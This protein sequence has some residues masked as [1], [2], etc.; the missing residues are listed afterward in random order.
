MANKY[1]VTGGTTTSWN[2]SSNWSLTSGGARGAAIPV[3]ADKVFFDQNAT[4]TVTSTGAANFPCCSL[5]VSAGLVTFALTGLFDCGSTSVAGDKEFFLGAGNVVSFTAIGFAFYTQTATT[6]TITTNGVPLTGL[7][8]P[9]GVAF[10]GSSA[11]ATGTILL[12]DNLSIAPTGGYGFTLTYGTLNLNNNTI[13][14]PSYNGSPTAATT[15]TIAFSTS[16]KLSIFGFGAT[17]TAT[18]T[19]SPFNVG[20]G[21]AHAVTGTPTV[22]MTYAG[23]TAFVMN[24]GTA[25][26]AQTFN[27]NFKAGTYALSFLNLASNS[28]R[29]IDFTGFSGTWNATSTATIYG[30]L[31]LSSG[32]TITAS[33]SLLTFA[34]T[35]VST[36]ILSFAGK[37]VDFSMTFSSLGSTYQFT[38]GLVIGAT[39]AR[40]VTLVNGTFD[41]NSQNI[42][43]GF[44]GSTWSM[45]T[46]TI[47]ISN[48]P[49]GTTMPFTIT[50]GTCNLTNCSFGGAVTFT[51]GALILLSNTT[52]A[53]AF[54]F[55]AG[56]LTLNN[57]TFTCSTSFLATGATTRSIAFGTGNITC[58]GSGTVWNQT[59]IGT[60]SYTGTPTVNITNA[61]ATATT[62]F[63]GIA[64]EAQALNFNFSGG[65]YTLTFLNTTSHAAKNVYFDPA[66]AGTLAA[67][68]ACTIY[69]GLSLSTSMALTVSTAVLTF[70]GTTALSKTIY[71]ASK[72]ID[73]PITFS[74]T[75]GTYQFTSGFSIGVTAAKNIIFVN[76]VF[77][78]NSQAITL[79]FAGST[80][81]MNTNTIAISNITS[82]TTMPFTI[83]S[84]TCNLTSC[85]F[86]GAVTFTAGALNLLS[87]TT[88][89]GAFT[90]TAGTLTLNNNAFTCS[91][92]FLA[93]GVGTRSVAFGTGNITCTGSGTVW[94]QTSIGTWSY[95]GTP[96]VNITNATT[97]ATTVLPGTMGITQALNFN[98]SGGAYTLT[99]MGTA[100]HHA[101]NVT[102]ATGWAGVWAAIGTS[103]RVYGQLT[104]VS[105]MTTATSAGRLSFAATSGTISPVFA[106]VTINCDIETAGSAPFLLVDALAM[107]SGKI[108]LING[109]TFDANNKSITGA[110][111]I[112][113]QSAAVTLQNL[114]TTAS[115]SNTSNVTLGS[116]ITCG[117]Y[118]H[119]AV[120]LNLATFQLTCSSFNSNNANT[121]TLAFGTGKIIVT[122]TGATAF[123][124][125]TITGLT[126]TGIPVVD[127]TYTGATAMTVAAGALAEASA[128]S[129]N[130]TAGTYALT[131]TGSTKD[132][133]FT[134]SSCSIASGGSPNIYGNL[135]LSATMTIP[136]QGAIHTFAATSGTK[137]ITSNGVIYGA[138][139][140]FAGVGGT[141][142]L[143]DNLSC[144]G[145]DGT[146]TSH[147][148][149]LTSGTFDLNGKVV[150]GSQFNSSNSNTRVIAFGTTGYFALT[151]QWNTTIVTGLTITGTAP[152][153]DIFYS[154]A[155]ATSIIPGAL[156]EANSI[157]F[158]F[159]AGT[160][161]LTFLATASH[162]AKNVN[163]TGFGGTWAAR[164]ANS[165]IY[166]NLTLSS[167]A[168][169]S[170]GANSGATI[171]GATS[172]TQ[173]LTF[174]GKTFDG[175]VTMDGTGG[176]R[177]LADA[178]VMGATRTLTL[179]NGTF[180]G[181]NK[182]IS[183]AGAFS[184]GIGTA[185]IKN[186]STAL[187]FAHSGGGSIL[188][189]GNNTVNNYTLSSGVLYLQGYTLTTLSFITGTGTKS[190]DFSAG[191]LVCTAST[192]TAFNNAVPLNFTTAQTT[193]ALGK[194]SMTGAS[195]KTF[196]GGASTYSCTLSNDGAGALT[197]TGGN[198]FTNIANGVQPTTFTFPAGNT[199]F[200]TYWNVNGGSGS[201]VTINSS[202]AGTAAGLNTN[203]TMKSSFVSL[204]DINM[205]TATGIAYVSTNVS[206]VTGWTFY[207]YAPG[208]GAFFSLFWQ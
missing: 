74:S 191:T 153:V 8:N 12:A 120:T 104:L 183:G 189:V 84:G 168:G 53:G 106:G 23:S 59:T 50:S 2:D 147:I 46:N 85:S 178:L 144:T 134:G 167:A 115:I 181:N 107:G 133:T 90:Y 161:S 3:A 182:T 122:G 70:A 67:T 111:T 126:I 102:F 194:I 43:L 207:A 98:F 18:T 5:R 162:S 94:D 64:T 61:T 130:F 88:I 199:N 155:T 139:I 87:N 32:M 110:A 6:L 41:I 143:Q 148:I 11:S 188:Q 135:I 96:T 39:A 112:F 146:Q 45:S 129:F 36:K 52:I 1:W 86:G 58:S 175:G 65:A 193:V 158:N 15:R 184:N 163:F 47:A 204:K 19:T 157:S 142:Q 171:F 60:F 125:S 101:N 27:F 174:N 172:G 66:W 164:T 205:V 28:A 132:L 44:A 76:G 63:S 100:S 4:Y 113:C 149:T 99:F 179:N 105:T 197:I 22:D 35:V 192:T 131:L 170:V 79:G 89:A 26:E 40:A 165:F 206:N 190:I 55:T 177:Q 137:T 103:C 80:W 77:D 152:R 109:N 9:Q 136:F 123:T 118:N 202:T 203:I 121:R 97:T 186:I 21:G 159:T 25:T 83:T 93:S 16:G 78:I 187:N 69:G 42:T 24:I 91:T 116:N 169:F 10:N 92:S 117:G 29:N 56:A 54:T 145:N 33:A 198:L 30:G 73:F 166:G 75:G 51:A 154:G 71:L 195:A 38:S 119:S 31:T 49:S 156:S 140:T 62:V 82:S 151:T 57:Y 14:T 13:T 34:G 81:S 180:D 201:L 127:V 114:S 128:I 176:T 20:T 7:T 17:G 160:Y 141:W 150:T 173:I 68:G 37:S 138:N 185:Y 108:L 196:V 208:K 200:T 72:G 124:L 48:V 95:T